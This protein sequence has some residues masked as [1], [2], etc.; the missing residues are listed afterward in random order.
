MYIIAGCNG[1]GKTTAS[2]T[3]LPEILKCSQFVNSDEFAKGLN[4]F[5]PNDASVRASRY[6]LIKIKYLI[7]RNMD[8]GV[9]TTL[10]TRSL[11]KIALAAQKKGY[12]VTVLYF[13]L[14]SPALAI[15]RV[16]ARVQA[17][18]HDIPTDVILRRYDKGLKYFFDDYSQFADRW[19]LADNSNY[20]YTV[21][22]QGWKDSMIVRDNRKYEQI[23]NYADSI[24]MKE[25]ATGADS[26]APEDENR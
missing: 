24:V 8:F 17:G 19:I 15:E 13:W 9:E 23:K 18:G 3:V 22:A 4:P 1:S 20:P 2:Y 16:R 21:V 25:P 6:M 5:N 10:A 12:F 11:R 7:D 14:D 26:E